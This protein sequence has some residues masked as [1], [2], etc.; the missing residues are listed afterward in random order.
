MNPSTDLLRAIFA[1]ALVVGMIWLLGYAL[2]KYGWKFGMPIA[3]PTKAQ[4]R[5]QI[6]ESMNLDAK[7]R[8]VLIKRD[9]T[10]HLIVLNATSTHVI[11]TAIESAIK[12]PANS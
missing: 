2:R 7:N 6:V 5:L 9:D 11:E 10:E 1:L 3:P 8:L 4:R 12:G